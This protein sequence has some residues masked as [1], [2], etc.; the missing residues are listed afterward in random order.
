MG[1]LVAAASVAGLLCAAP[2]YAQTP[3]EFYKGKTVYLDI[4][5]SVGGDYDT[6]GR[7]VARHIKDHIPGTP[8]VVPQNIVGAAGLTLANEMYNTLP[9]D[10]TVFG[11]FNRGM[12]FEPVL[13]TAGA[14]YDPR[15]MNWLGSPELD[16]I[17]CF[18]RKDAAV[19]KMEDLFSKELVVGGTGPGAESVTVPNLLVN[20]MGMKIKVVKGFA[21]SAE[22][23]LGVDRGEVEGGC[24]S[25]VSV[26][27]QS[28]F[29]T[30]VVQ[31]LLQV[32]PAPDPR[33]KDVPL[34][35]KFVKNEADRAAIDFFLARFAIGRPFVAPPGVP[36]DRVA[37][38][39]QAF[40]D[41][42][43]DAQ[44]LEDAT[45]ARLNPS[46]VTWQHIT[47]AINAAYETPKSAIERL[48]A[49]LR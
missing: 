15:K 16:I 11:V 21:G 33:L 5:E 30:G 46:P 7:V 36:A 32:A 28:I 45:K 29:R 47:E 13:G 41:T 20:L 22:V 18:A 12:P 2:G 6:W 43:T 38:L 44:F 9:K 31:V 4:G 40:A 3:A 17:A 19:Q 27:R 48:S 34:A 42:M 23:Y 37:A 8:N 24:N 35:T 26:S 14:Q 49:A 25:F 1:R 10:G 39:R